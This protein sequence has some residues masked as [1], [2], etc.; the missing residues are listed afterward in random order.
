MVWTEQKGKQPVF[1]KCVL[2]QLHLYVI[3]NIIIC[4][5]RQ[6]PVFVPPMVLRAMIH[7]A[8]HLSL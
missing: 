5:L 6:I 7:E 8:I 1:A 3:P 2:P 4:I